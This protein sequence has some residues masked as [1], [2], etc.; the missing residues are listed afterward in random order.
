M[1]SLD[2]IATIA[3]GSVPGGV[4]SMTSS[5]AIIYSRARPMRSCHSVAGLEAKSAR[6]R[7]VVPSRGLIGDGQMVASPNVLL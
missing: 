5:S 7:T 6:T 3:L 1:R 2:A 4:R